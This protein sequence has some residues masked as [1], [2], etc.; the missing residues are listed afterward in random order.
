M[1]SQVIDKH[2]TWLVLTVTTEERKKADKDPTYTPKETVA[3][4]ILGLSESDARLRLK[5]AIQ[6]HVYPK[7]A[8]LSSMPLKLSK[9]DNADFLELPRD[10]LKSIGKCL[11]TAE[12]SETKNDFG[13][14]IEEALAWIPELATELTL[15]RVKK[16]NRDF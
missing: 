11:N 6:R 8:Q 12:K 13:T 10:V 2:R 9:R 3:G 14:A 4:R 5:R 7:S 15:L 16:K 1:K